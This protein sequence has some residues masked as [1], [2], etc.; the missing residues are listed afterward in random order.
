V[1]GYTIRKEITSLAA[2]W[3]WAALSGL[4]SG[5]FPNAGL[6]YPKSVEKPPFQTRAEIERQIARGGLSDDDIGELWDGLFLTL[7][8]TAEVLAFI[9]DSARHGFLYPMVCFAAHTGAR[10]SEILRSRIS[11]L[12]LDTA[13]ATIREKKRV[14]GVRTTRRVPLSPFLVGVLRAW[15]A[16]HPGGSFTFCQVGKVWKSKTKR[17]GPTP[18]TRD[19]AHDHLRRTLGSGPWSVVRGWHVSGTASSRTAPH[20]GWTSGSL[21][22]GSVTRPRRCAGATGTYS[23][24]SRRLPSARSSTGSR[25][26]LRSRTSSAWGIIHSRYRPRPLSLFCARI[27][28]RRHH[29][30]TVNSALPRISATSVVE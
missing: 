24:T 29:S 13:S 17:N 30:R 11:D 1:T 19:E 26:S 28:P 9:R 12:D 3:K 8:E 23:R 25:P 22:P 15:L 4:V 20:A 5:T 27:L 10:R 14:K 21:T 7:P 18:I 16:D 6:N 2:A